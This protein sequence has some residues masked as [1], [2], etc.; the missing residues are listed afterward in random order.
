M[1]EI[2]SISSTEGIRKGQIRKR[3]QKADHNWPENKE[4]NSC[5]FDKKSCT[6]HAQSCHVALA[7]VQGSHLITEVC[8]LLL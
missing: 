2:E 6:D 5:A 1:S 8:R 3:G 4:E 7:S